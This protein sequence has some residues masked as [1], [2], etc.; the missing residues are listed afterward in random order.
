LNDAFHA[1][2]VRLAKSDILRQTLDKLFCLPFA[3]PSAL[4]TAPLRLPDAKDRFIIGRE[5]HC[6]IIEAIAAR[7][8]SRAE[9]VAHEHARLT[10]KHIEV[11][12][13][14]GDLASLPGGLLIKLVSDR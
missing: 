3:S 11:A 2:V 13:A 4:V 1:E 7:Q 5:Q 6:A 12:L 14:N 8:G 9:S 10:R